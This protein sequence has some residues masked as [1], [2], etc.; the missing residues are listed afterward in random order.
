MNNI[1]KKSASTESLAKKNVEQKKKTNSVD[2]HIK[3]ELLEEKKPLD[4]WKTMD[5]LQG[6]F[7]RGESL[8]RKKWSWVVVEHW[9]MPT[10]PDVIKWK[11]WN[12]VY[13]LEESILDWGS[14][15]MLSIENK[16]TIVIWFDET[17]SAKGEYYMSVVDRNWKKVNPKDHKLIAKTFIDLLNF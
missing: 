7:R 10:E 14:S 15:Y 16:Y 17:T 11:K 12:D 9:K 6:L 5:K 8:S 13:R 2:E 1:E 3:K 4:V